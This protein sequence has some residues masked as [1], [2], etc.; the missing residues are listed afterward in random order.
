MQKM[1]IDRREAEYLLTVLR[2]DHRNDRE[3]DLHPHP[4]FENLEA[5][6]LAVIAAEEEVYQGDE[7]M[8]PG[9]RYR[10]YPGQGEG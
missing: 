1:T 3:N 5:K 7:R 8:G 10:D 4:D 2:A 6:M 9:Y